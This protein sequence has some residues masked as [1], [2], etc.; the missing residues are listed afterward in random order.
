MKKLLFVLAFAFIGQQS[1]SQMYIVTLSAVDPVVSG[2]DYSLG[3]GTLTKTHPSGTQTYTCITMNNWPNT[4]GLS[5]LNTELNSIINTL[6]GYKLI[7][8]V[9]NDNGVISNSDLRTGV[10]WFFA[11]P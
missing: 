9:A 10:I 3:E 5:V 2:C 4:N 1:F 7:E 8:I 6:P 11:A